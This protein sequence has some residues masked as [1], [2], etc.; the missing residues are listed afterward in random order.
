[1]LAR[2]RCGKPARREKAAHNPKAMLDM[3][4]DELNDARQQ[5]QYDDVDNKRSEWIGS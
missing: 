2:D 4:Q 3:Y 5:T 1:M